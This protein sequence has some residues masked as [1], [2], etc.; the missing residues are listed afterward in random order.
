MFKAKLKIDKMSGLNNL[1]KGS[2]SFYDCEP[3]SFDVLIVDEAHRLNKNQ[4]CFQ[5]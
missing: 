5:I 3:N 4:V 2:G 1:F